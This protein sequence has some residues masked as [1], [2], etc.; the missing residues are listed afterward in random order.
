MSFDVAFIHAERC[1]GDSVGDQSFATA[2]AF[3]GQR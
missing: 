1:F 2:V 3:D